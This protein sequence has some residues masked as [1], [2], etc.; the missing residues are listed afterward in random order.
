MKIKIALVGICIGLLSFIFCIMLHSCAPEKPAQSYYEKRYADGDSTVYIRYVDQSGQQQSFFMDWILFNSLYS[1]G[2]YNSCYGYYHS[3]P[4]YFMTP[5]YRRYNTYSSP[6]IINHSHNYFG[7]SSSGSSS[8]NSYSSPSRSYSSPSRGYSSP[9]RSYSSPSRSYSSPSRSY[10]S[11]S[12]SYSSPS[13]S[14][15]H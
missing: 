7:G 5:R 12:R 3:H 2:G 8:R 13:R 4:S 10:S 1:T 11:P 14:S 9:S 15:R 6:V